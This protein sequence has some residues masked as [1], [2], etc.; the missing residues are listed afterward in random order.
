MCVTLAH[1]QEAFIL[2]FFIFV[3]FHTQ[4]LWAFHCYIVRQHSSGHE[5]LSGILYAKYA[6]MCRLA[7]LQHK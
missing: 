6:T 3:H 2:R 5:F 7:L 1:I 4:R